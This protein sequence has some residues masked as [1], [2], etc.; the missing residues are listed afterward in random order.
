MPNHLA[1]GT[2]GQPRET[3]A[4]SRASWPWIAVA[5]VIGVGKTEGFRL[6]E[7][8]VWGWTIVL[9]VTSGW[10]LLRARPVLTA[11]FAAPAI[12]ILLKPHPAG[13]GVAVGFALFAILIAL[14]VAIGTALRYLDGRGT[15]R[16]A[17][18]PASDA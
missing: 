5:L 6:L 9:G 2:A 10:S 7:H 17:V 4:R 14:F 12:S 16:H 13:V 11:L 1:P 3:P 18:T 8:H 15:P